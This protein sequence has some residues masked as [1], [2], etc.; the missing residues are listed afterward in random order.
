ML[1]SVRSSINSLPKDVGNV[2]LFNYDYYQFSRNYALISNN[3]E[4][5]VGQWNV[6][7]SYFNLA[8]LPEDVNLL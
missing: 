4:G 8:W 7:G 1:P 5:Y 3:V 2:N 6:V